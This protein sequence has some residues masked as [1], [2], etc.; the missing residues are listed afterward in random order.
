MAERMSK[1]L[2]AA[3]ALAAAPLAS[4]A[5]QPRPAAIP[6]GP[7][8]PLEYAAKFVCGRSE[9]PNDIAGNVPLGRYFTLVNIHNP[10]K[11]VRFTY[12]VAVAGFAVAGP[13]IGF[14]P[15]L[16]LAYDEALEI[17]CAWI[18][19]RLQLNGVL[20]NQ[21][22]RTGFLVVQS[23][24]ELDVVAVYMTSPTGAGQVSSLHTERVPVRHVMDPLPPP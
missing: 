1:T 11:P 10:G 21:A 3:L 14:Q 23:P 20:P 6:E 18:A 2:L 19:R 22:F 7:V 9:A 13:T 24:V 15:P 17:D 4:A 12:T 8:A 5:A 16:R